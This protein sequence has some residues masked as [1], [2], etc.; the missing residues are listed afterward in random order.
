MKRF[1]LGEAQLYLA[2]VQAQVFQL[3]LFCS[4]HSGKPDNYLQTY[5][6]WFSLFLW[7]GNFNE[8]FALKKVS[9]ATDICE[10][11]FLAVLFQDNITT[12]I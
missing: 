1:E 9:E 2:A 12:K 8:T 10:V 4:K 5:V 6:R 7:R 11:T 3:I